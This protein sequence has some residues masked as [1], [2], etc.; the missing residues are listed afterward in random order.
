M[1]RLASF[2]EE[3]REEKREKERRKKKKEAKREGAR[4]KLK[5]FEKKQ[6]LPNLAISLIIS[7]M[8]CTDSIIPFDHL[9]GT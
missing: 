9:L 4:K 2:L 1:F 5:C 3:K 7:L 6:K 8:S